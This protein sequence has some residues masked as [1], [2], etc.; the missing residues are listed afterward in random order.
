MVLKRAIEIVNGM[1]Q[2]MFNRENPPTIDYT[3][4]EM[5]E[6]NRKIASKNKKATTFDD[7]TIAAIYV[8]IKCDATCNSIARVNSK[9]VYVL[10]KPR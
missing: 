7:V 2:W 4:E 9:E 1:E 8:G 5:I 10:N 3:L 6:A